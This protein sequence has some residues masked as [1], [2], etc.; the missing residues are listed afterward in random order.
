MAAALAAAVA[1]C[2]LARLTRDWRS[3]DSEQA[4]N[5]EEASR[6]GRYGMIWCYDYIPFIN[7]YIPV[8]PHKA[9]AEVSKIG[10]L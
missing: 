8:V 10:N 4:W 1:V 6:S 5:E 9:V 2:G 7:N 3:C